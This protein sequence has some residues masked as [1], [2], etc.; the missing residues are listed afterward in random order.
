MFYSLELLEIISPTKKGNRSTDP[1]YEILAM[2][3][4]RYKH[5]KARSVRL[6]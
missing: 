3:L 4:P 1:M 5:L 6:K 2:V